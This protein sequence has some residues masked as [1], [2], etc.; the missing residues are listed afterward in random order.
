MQAGGRLR[1][2]PPPEQFFEVHC[3]SSK[4]EQAPSGIQVNQDIQ[5][6]VGL[7]LIARRGAEDAD[8][9]HTV[10]RGDCMNVVTVSALQ[11]LKGHGITGTL[12]PTGFLALEEAELCIRP[13]R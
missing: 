6:A 2:D 5:V 3:E 12:L 1:V 7:G 13:P 11:F 4:I 8:I 9:S 10:P